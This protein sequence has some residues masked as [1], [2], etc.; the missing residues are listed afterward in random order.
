MGARGDWEMIG[1]FGVDARKQANKKARITQIS[2]IKK[3][4]TRKG[5]V[6]ASRGSSLSL[7]VTDEIILPLFSIPAP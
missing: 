5:I 3:R 2:R 1:E 4:I 7:H 6:G